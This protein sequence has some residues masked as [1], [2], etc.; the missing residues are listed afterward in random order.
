MRDEN[1]LLT[2]IGKVKYHNRVTHKDAAD[3]GARGVVDGDTLPDI[4]F[5]CADPPI[6]GFRTWPLIKVAHLD[7]NCSKHKLTN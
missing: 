7:K 3:A 5:T 4:I 2:H 1:G 6:G